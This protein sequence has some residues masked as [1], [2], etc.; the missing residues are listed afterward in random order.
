MHTMHTTKGRDDADIYLVRQALR[1]EGTLHVEYMV[2]VSGFGTLVSAP[3]INTTW[4]R[5]S[6]IL[7]VAKLTPAGFVEMTPYALGP[8]VLAMPSLKEIFGTKRLPDCFLWQVAPEADLYD[9]SCL[10]FTRRGGRLWRWHASSW[11]V[12]ARNVR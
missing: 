4:R 5:F 3:T 8:T 2:E 10:V 7:R 11:P 1:N 12:L 6:G 9:E